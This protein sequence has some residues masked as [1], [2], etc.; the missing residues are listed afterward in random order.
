MLSTAARRWRQIS[1]PGRVG[2]LDFC[3]WSR[4]AALRFLA[5]FSAQGQERH[6]GQR[7]LHGGA[8]QFQQDALARFMSRG[9]GSLGWF[10][11]SFGI[12]ALV[13]VVIWNPAIVWQ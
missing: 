9:P 3:F 5:G 10:K 7:H 6:Q 8:Q 1:A 4:V 2:R 13:R 12:D 11:R